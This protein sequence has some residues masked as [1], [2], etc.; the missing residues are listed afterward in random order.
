MREL[1]L[2]TWYVWVLVAIIAIVRLFKPTIKGVIGEKTV[3]AVLSF[4]D[5]NKYKIINDVIVE[6]VNGGTSQIDHVVVSNYGIFVIETKNYKGKIYGDEHNQYWTQVLGRN[7]EK[8]YSPIKQN[9]GHIKALKHQLLTYPDIELISII[10]F[11]PEAE[12]KVKTDKEVIYTTKLLK[13]IR[14]YTNE[15][16]SNKVKDE[17][18]NSILSLNINSKEVKKEHISSIRN[19]KKERIKNVGNDI[20]PKCGGAL[21]NKK[22]R[23]GYFKGCSNHPKC[24]FTASI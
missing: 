17:I 2:S 12:L 11:S 19:N 13:T 7:K 16:I 14:K 5:S 10:V 18:Y 21:V 9:Y 20:C 1:F 22:G 6:K 15:T 24:D 23:Y 8:F 3:T 4:L